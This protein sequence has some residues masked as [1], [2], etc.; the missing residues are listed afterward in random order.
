MRAKKTNGKGKMVAEAGEANANTDIGTGGTNKA[1]DGEA[2]KGKPGKGKAGK[3]KAGKGKSGKC[4]A[5]KG[6]TG[7]CNTGKGNA[8]KRRNKEMGK[9]NVATSAPKKKNMRG[10][11]SSEA[12]KSEWTE[13]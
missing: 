8:R 2:G 13:K 10:N 7:K 5:G 9:G 11:T 12:E 3:V 6:E 1:G 4:E